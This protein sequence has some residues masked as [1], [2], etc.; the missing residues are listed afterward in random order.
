MLWM[1]LQRG[2]RGDRVPGKGGRGYFPGVSNRFFAAEYTK[3]KIYLDLMMI[4]K[5]QWEGNS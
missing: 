1:L 5:D 2:T 3:K 4:E